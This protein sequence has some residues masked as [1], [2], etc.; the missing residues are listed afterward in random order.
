MVVVKSLPV[1]TISTGNAVFEVV[2]NRLRF[3]L[4][5]NNIPR[6]TQAHIHLGRRGVNGPIVA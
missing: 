2:G 1:R 5:V 6:M 3:R 4:V